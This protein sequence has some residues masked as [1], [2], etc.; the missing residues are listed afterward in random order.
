PGRPDDARQREQDRQHHHEADEQLKAAAA[1]FEAVGEDRQMV[2]EVAPQP[3]AAGGGGAR[4]GPT[5][6]ARTASPAPERAPPQ[7][8]DPKKGGPEQGGTS[9]GGAA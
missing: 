9:A 8:T 6:A 7:R 2:P 1:I 4:W 3:R 5:V